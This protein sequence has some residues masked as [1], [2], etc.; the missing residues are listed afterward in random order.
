MWE[1]SR[2][3]R[4]L[5]LHFHFFFCVELKHISICLLFPPLLFF[6]G[7][8]TCAAWWL[9][10]DG[11]NMAIIGTKVIIMTVAECF[12]TLTPDMLPKASF[13]I[14]VLSLPASA[15]TCV[16]VCVCNPELVCTITPQIWTRD[17]KNFG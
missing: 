14:R 13:G 1:T 11:Q 5:T 17:A 16:R 3:I 2:D 10:F 9:T 12:N 7:I 6:S 8:P 4:D 15:C